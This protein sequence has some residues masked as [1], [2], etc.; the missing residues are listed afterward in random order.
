MKSRL[1]SVCSSYSQ[2]QSFN[3]DE[4]RR[5]P[6]LTE[7]ASSPQN[8]HPRFGHERPSIRQTTTGSQQLL[9]Q[10]VMR[11][12]SSP[13]II[14]HAT[15]SRSFPL[16]PELT[17]F[18]MKSSG[19]IHSGRLENFKQKQ[20]LQ[21]RAGTLAPLRTATFSNASHLTGDLARSRRFQN[22]E[23]D[24]DQRKQQCARS[25]GPPGANLSIIPTVQ[26][27]R[28]LDRG[29]ASPIS[30]KLEISIY[31]VLSSLPLVVAMFIAWFNHHQV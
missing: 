4:P 23:E 26:G 19:D 10:A 29:V 31:I 21:A 30:R 2:E 25:Q 18:K 15:K 8:T 11:S 17:E 12:N 13:S 16:Q 28:H 5:V 20:L 7:C 22:L 14:S 24:G 6:A 9:K 3:S 27:H 1:R